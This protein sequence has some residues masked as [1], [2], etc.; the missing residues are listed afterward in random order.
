MLIRWLA[1]SA[2]R[3]TCR[4][5]RDAQHRDTGIVIGRGRHVD[6]AGDLRLVVQQDG[7]GMAAVD[8]V[9]AG[10]VGDDHVGD[11][12]DV[13]DVQLIGTDA[14]DQPA[15]GRA[16]E[17]L[18]RPTLLQ[19][20]AT[21]ATPVSNWRLI[22]DQ[23][24]MSGS[25]ALGVELIGD[26]SDDLRHGHGTSRSGL[27]SG[28]RGRQGPADVADA[29]L[30]QLDPAGVESAWRTG[31][32]PPTSTQ[33]ARNTVPQTPFAD[34]RPHFAVGSALFGVFVTINEE[35]IKL[36]SDLGFPAGAVRRVVPGLRRAQGRPQED[37][38]RL[39]RHAHHHL[40]LGPGERA[41]GRLHHAELRQG[42]DRRSHRLG[43]GQPWHV[44][45][46]H[47][48]INMGRRGPNGTSDDD[49]KMLADGLNQLGQNT[50]DLG[51]KL[52]L[53]PHIW[54]PVERPE[55]IQ[56]LMELTDPRYV[57]LLPGHRPSEPGRRRPAGADSRVLRPRRRDPLEGHE[58][59]VS[60]VHRPDADPRGAQPGDPLQ[61][62]RTAGGVDIPGI[63]SMLLERGYDGWVTLD[64]DPP[65]PNEGEG[66]YADKLRINH[67]FLLETLRV[68]T[69]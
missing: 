65:R 28:L 58:A 47:F 4:T 66:T 44:R 32:P 6:A 42:D 2:G 59:G 19:G 9:R 33:Q 69:L 20:S 40:E 29:G 55:E 50:A 54:G 18:D 43:P 36:V 68:E 16:R 17:I 1:R 35:Q 30:H 11:D 26:A 14:R 51:V 61:G 63:W 64:L 62:S 7:D 13:D 45:L 23:G 56:R 46:P 24:I 10:A 25:G 39:R 27:A 21:V 22:A 12:A 15:I 5:V 38:G 41:A 53:H 3:R 8:L 34:G 48:K 37:A 67:R 60:R 52:S 57:Y 31:Y 49:L